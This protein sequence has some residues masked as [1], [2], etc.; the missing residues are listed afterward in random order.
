MTKITI[1]L[2][3]SYQTSPRQA[4]RGWGG[5]T[6]TTGRSAAAAMGLVSSVNHSGCG[7]EAITAGS[8]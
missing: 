8:Q 5:G 4:E 3:N 1:T 2:A 7:L 6:Q